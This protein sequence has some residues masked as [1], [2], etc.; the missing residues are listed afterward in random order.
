[1][2]L[3][4]VLLLP[5]HFFALVLA[6]SMLGQKRQTVF[7]F[8]H[9]QQDLP[10]RDCLTRQARVDDASS[11]QVLDKIEDESVASFCS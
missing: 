7:T 5:R 8:L 3:L 1:M 10:T 2:W 4:Y 9:P 11:L 6:L